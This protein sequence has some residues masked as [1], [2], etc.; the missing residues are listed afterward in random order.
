ME[1]S[2]NVVAHVEKYKEFV[3]WCKDSV[4]LKRSTNELEAELVV[5]FGMFTERY[6]S[7]VKVTPPTIVTATSHQTN[8]FET[9][10]TE[11]KFSPAS[12]PQ[13]CWVTFEIDFQFRS[14]IY[15]NLSEVFLNDVVK[16]MVKAFE[17]QCQKT[18]GDRS[19]RR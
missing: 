9:L 12:D 5:G 8:L 10:R 16:N 15:N 3:P 6:I 14:A 17:Q 7:Q 4:V 18:Y 1:E 11:W 19:R 2:F 13:N